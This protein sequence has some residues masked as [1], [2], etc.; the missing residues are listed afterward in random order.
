MRKLG[1]I[2]LLAEV[3]TCFSPAAI[4]LLIWL[5]AFFVNLGNEHQNAIEKMQLAVLVLAGAAGLAAALA[6]LSF[7]LV[8]SRLFSASLVL[9][10]SLA[11]L[12]LSGWAAVGFLRSDLSLFALIPAAPFLCGL[13]LLYLGRAYFTA[14][15][16]TPESSGS[17]RD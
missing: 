5:L 17:A 15:R 1:R 13:H 11:G 2:A 8:G 4:G 14:R 12:V 6:L 16:A 10:C 3:V 9:S 7:I